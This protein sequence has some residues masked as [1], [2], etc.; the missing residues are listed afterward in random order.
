MTSLVAGLCFGVLAGV[1]AYLTSQNSRNVWV[2][3]GTS[4][5]LAAVMGIRFLNSW[6][7]MP[8]GL[9]TLASALMLGKI[10]IGMR[11]RPH[12]S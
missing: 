12:Q 8:A 1:G 3:L 9:M 2:S 7:F 5:T 6:K 11:K 10:A 4:G